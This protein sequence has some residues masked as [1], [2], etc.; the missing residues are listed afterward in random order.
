[1]AES[2]LVDLMN[3]DGILQNLEGDVLSKNDDSGL[4]RTG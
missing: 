1:M 4:R 2:I 3:G